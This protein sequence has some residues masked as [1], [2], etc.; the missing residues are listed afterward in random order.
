[1]SCDNE[2]ETFLLLFWVG[3]GPGGGNVWNKSF[4]GNGRNHQAFQQTKNHK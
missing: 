3:G 1:V 4:Y 2:I